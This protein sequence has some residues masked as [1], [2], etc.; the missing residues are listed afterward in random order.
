MPSC[1]NLMNCW[2]DFLV[3]PKFLSHFSMPLFFESGLNCV[4]MASFEHVDSSHSPDQPL[5][6]LG[7]QGRKGPLHQVFKRFGCILVQ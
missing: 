5:E 6:Y 4:A 3:V 1:K 7:P 2:A